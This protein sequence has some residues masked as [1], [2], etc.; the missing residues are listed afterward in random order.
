MAPALWGGAGLVRPQL[1][2]MGSERVLAPSSEF[3]DPAY[4]GVPG[5]AWGAEDPLGL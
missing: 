3:Q 5:K 2:T 1:R 4:R